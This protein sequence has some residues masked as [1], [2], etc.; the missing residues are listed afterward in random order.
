MR[1]AESH[2][3]LR[4]DT[5]R[6][7]PKST[8]VF[9]CCTIAIVM[10]IGT[11]SARAQA[12]PQDMID[13]GLDGYARTKLSL[14]VPGSR[15]F[16]E[17]ASLNGQRSGG[18]S[19]FAYVWPLS[20]QFRVQ[21]ALT[22]LDPANYTPLLRQFSDEARAR[23]WNVAGGGYRS[24]VSSGATL[25]Y[26]DNAHMAVALME[27]YRIT[28]ES[29][30]LDRARETYDF[31]LS[32]E[33]LAGGGGIYFN[34]VEHSTKETIS[35]LQGAR[36]ALMLY[37][38]TEEAGYLSDATRLHQW[39]QS[40][41][42]QPDGL[43]LEKYYLTGPKAGT[44][45]D[46][47]LVNAAGDAISL[48]LEFYAS[49]GQVTHLQEAQRIATRSLSRFVNSTTGAIN[50][51]GFW[52]FELVDAFNNLSLVVNNPLWL[53]KT[54]DALEWLH[55]NRRDPN[56]HYGRLWGRGGFQST[57]LGSWHLNDQAA[58]ARSYL[59]TGLTALEYLRGD[60]NSDGVVDAADYV[61]W[62]ETDGLQTG[63]DAWG[64][65]FGRTVVAGSLAGVTAP[66]PANW[67]L[68]ITASLGW[69]LREAHRHVGPFA[70][71]HGRKHIG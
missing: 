60:Y 5:F 45:G 33:D 48:H 56:G 21:N 34:Q 67:V 13:W 7:L 8:I 27:A 36:A 37:Q 68:L 50:D 3:K 65:N 25:F 40:H 26:D 62:R 55:Q 29:I 28:G 15:L 66:E 38:A 10:A 4:S 47:T 12:T 69:W 54:M 52:A 35:T 51:E 16:A 22:R 30:Y 9:L 46:F 32:G 17:T 24:G 49:T 20:T 61:V 42:R 59:Y 57:A 41:T 71:H 44:A 14:Q 18:D 43:F 6:M 11:T 70:C 53:S 19:G 64:A 63:Y 58:A 23:Y 31:V 1:A 2:E 39:A